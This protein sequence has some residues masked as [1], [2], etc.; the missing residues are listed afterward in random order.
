DDWRR[1]KADE[2]V[3]RTIQRLEAKGKGIVL[4]HDIQPVTVLALPK[5]LH[6][7]KARGFR[8]VHVVPSGGDR[9]KTVTQPEQWLL[10]GAGPRPKKPWP[11]GLAPAPAERPELPAPGL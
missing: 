8:V 6:E 2:V 10:A 1:I 11:Q 9:P 5:I 7:L 4:L 3:K